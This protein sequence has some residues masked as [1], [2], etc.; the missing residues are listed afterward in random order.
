M[1]S[2]EVREHAGGGGGGEDEA[3]TV[4]ADLV[5]AAA[6]AVASRRRWLVAGEG[7]EY[8]AG[9][10]ASSL[11]P[12]KAISQIQQRTGFRDPCAAPLLALLEHLGLSLPR[13]AAGALALARGALLRR[14]HQHDDE[15]GEAGK[16]DSGKDVISKDK[17]KLQL[18]QLSHKQLLAL[19]TASFP[20]V[21][22]PELRAVPLAVLERLRPV[23]PEFLKQ[24]IAIPCRDA[25]G[26]IS[27][28]A[29]KL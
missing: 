6:A 15:H 11:D 16:D 22:I 19:L 26:I 5:S 28:H 21:S 3:A 24:A 12:T 13:A 17:S 25:S 18:P 8:V 9:V 7:S 4:A 10:L 20:Y 1:S 23:P 14:V 27:S 2:T 29:A